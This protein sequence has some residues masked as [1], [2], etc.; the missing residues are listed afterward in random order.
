MKYHFILLFMVLTLPVL[1]QRNAI[2]DAVDEL[3]EQQLLDKTLDWEHFG[4]FNFNL[5]GIDNSAS[6]YL[7]IDAHTTVRMY[8]LAKTDC[9]MYF[10]VR[11]KNESY[12]FGT[13]DELS[14]ET[15][16]EGFKAATSFHTYEKPSVMNINF[17]IRW[18][19]PSMLDTPMRLMVFYVNKNSK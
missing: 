9:Y 4:T 18:G 7:N 14:L 1:S 11:D 6:T 16:Y 17:G 10:E 5:Q 2:D 3:R 12:T 15:E 8:M 13:N 19:C